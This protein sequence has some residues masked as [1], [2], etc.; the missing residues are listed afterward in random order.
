MEKMKPIETKKVV[1]G[2]MT[3]IELNP[4]LVSEI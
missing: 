4:D 1:Q 2:C 3:Y